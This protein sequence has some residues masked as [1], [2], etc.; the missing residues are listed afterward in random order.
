MKNL[1]ATLCLTVVSL[2]TSLPSFAADR[3]VCQVNAKKVCND[4]GCK[5]VEILG[6]HYRIIDKRSGTYSIGKDQ[7]RLEGTEVAGAFEIFKV[8]GVSFMKMSV[9]DIPLTGLKRGQ[10]LEVRDTF[11]SVVTSF[12]ICTF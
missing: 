3:Y 2:V 10:F 6:D 8:G 11:L 9:F 12:G 1:I 7:F 4:K 5:D